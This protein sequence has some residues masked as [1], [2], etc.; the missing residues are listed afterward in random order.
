MCR[1][2][3]DVM[4]EFVSANQSGLREER[5]TAQ[6]RSSK[7]RRRGSTSDAEPAG[8]ATVASQPAAASEPVRKTD[9][10]A[11]KTVTASRT[12]KFRTTRD[13]AT[14]AFQNTISEIRKITW[15]DAETTRNLTGLVIAMSTVLG[16]LL[17]GIDFLLL[18]LFETF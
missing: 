15:P 6:R 9:A 13:R 10:A 4:L 12:S 17:G 18:K 14:K 2:R 7:G 11:T 5:M 3:N 16:L 8:Q 1:R